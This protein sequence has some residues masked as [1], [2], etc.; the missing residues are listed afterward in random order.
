MSHPLEHLG[1][2]YTLHLSLVGKPVV[3]FIFVVIELFSLSPTVET[4]WA[5]INRSRRFSKG[6]DHTGADFRGMGASPTKDCWRQ[7][8]RVIAV[9]YGIKVSAVH[10]LVVSQY[11]RLTDGRT[12]RQTDGR[13]DRQNFDSNTVRCITCCRTV[14]TKNSLFEPPFWALRGNVRTPS[15]A[16]WKA[17]VDFI[18]V[19]IELFSLSPTVE[20]LW[21]EIGRSRRFS[22][23]GGSLWPQISEGRGHRPPTTV[24]VRKLEWLPFREVSKYSQCVV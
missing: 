5:E 21:A 16:H 1:V 7:K 2:T 13:T 4:L 8:T 10:H 19:V 24:G 12:N 22:K 6:V 14:K 23:G 11:T 18:F 15:M 9:S 3:D 20:T 17:V